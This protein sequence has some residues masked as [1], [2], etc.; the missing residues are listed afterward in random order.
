MDMMSGLN[1]RASI[2][3]NINDDGVSSVHV[4]PEREGACP[5][6]V[7][8][9]AHEIVVGLG[10]ISRVEL[11]PGEE[12]LPILRRI[13]DAIISGDVVRIVRSGGSS[14]RILLD[15]AN[16]VVADGGGILSRFGRHTEIRCNPY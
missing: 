5:F 7:A 6:S 2:D 9:S 12:D 14:F 11:G 1:D 3:W 4:V 15:G 10:E 13:I 8:W 16:V